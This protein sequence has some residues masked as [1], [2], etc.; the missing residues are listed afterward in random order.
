MQRRAT[1]GRRPRTRE[2]RTDGRSGPRPP[3]ER[4]WAPQHERPFT[5]C[6]P[7]ALWYEKNPSQV[8]GQESFRVRSASAAQRRLQPAQAR[9][10][11]R[12]AEVPTVNQSVSQ[13]F[14]GPA[15]RSPI[16]QLTVQ[17][18]RCELATIQSHSQSQISTA[19]RTHLTRAILSV[20]SQSI[21][22]RSRPALTPPP[23]LKILLRRSRSN[24][25]VPSTVAPGGYS[26]VA[27][28]VNRQILVPAE[29]GTGRR[30]V[31]RNVQTTPYT[32]GARSCKVCIRVFLAFRAGAF[33]ANRS[34]ARNHVHV[35][36]LYNM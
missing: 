30:N 20:Y 14:H 36:I 32:T 5:L 2:S 4:G 3:E 12:S 15:P 7:C 28:E 19:D 24:T 13:L 33:H 11:Q 18:R 34:T 31:L 8:P 10:A 26:I 9:A 17:L 21:I 22:S 29:V 25:T 35:G 6:S 16:P 27:N 1:A 23:A